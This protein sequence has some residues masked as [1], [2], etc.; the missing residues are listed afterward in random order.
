MN[1]SEQ[2][3]EARIIFD[4]NS[5][6]TETLLVTPIGQNLYRMEESSVFGEVS[7]HDIIETEPQD[8]GSL[9]FL[10]VHTRSELRTTSW[11]VSR[12]L[13]ESSNLSTLLVR[14]IAVGGHWERIF[15]GWL[16]VHLPPAEND[17]LISDFNRLFDQFR[18][19]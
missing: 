12:S 15:G 6:T 17:A 16:I 9:R 11:V 19:P 14:V 7:Y 18:E 2:A 13:A 8:N 10:A 4:N 3:C 5:A 1:G